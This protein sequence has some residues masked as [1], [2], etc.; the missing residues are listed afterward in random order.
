VIKLALAKVI[1]HSLFVINSL[2]LFMNLSH[3]QPVDPSVRF[4][5]SIE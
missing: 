1:L 3:S 2:I 5:R 4:E